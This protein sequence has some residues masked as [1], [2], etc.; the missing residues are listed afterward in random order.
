MPPLRLRIIGL[1]AH[2]LKVLA[3]VRTDPWKSPIGTLTSPLISEKLMR[4]RDVK[5]V[6]M[7]VVLHTYKLNSKEIFE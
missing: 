5:V 4:V 1:S 7:S 6:T 3:R 2:D